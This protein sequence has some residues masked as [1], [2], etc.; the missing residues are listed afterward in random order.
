MTDNPSEQKIVVGL[1]ELLWDLLPEG[2]R[3]GGA[4]ANFAVMAGRLGDHAVIASRLGADSLGEQARNVLDALPVDCSFLQTDAEFATG[5]VTVSFSKGEPH[6]AIHQ[7]AAWDYLTLTPEWRSLAQRADAVCFGTLAQ[8]DAIARHTIL[9]FLDATRPSCVRVFDVNLR[10]PFWTADALRY[11]LGRSTILKLNARELPLV[12]EKTGIC[13]HPPP[14][15]D[16]EV[17]RGAQRLLDR[18]PLAMVCV[19]LG[20]EGS[21]LVTREHSHRRHGLAATVRDTIGAGD[22]FTAALTHYHLEGALLPVLNEA[23]NR[24][25]AWMAS[26]T[27]AMPPLPAETLASMAVEIRRDA[28]TLGQVGL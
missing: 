21:L 27:G 22:A 13:P 18:Y 8:R 12:L 23:G 6:Y 9:E 25:G 28:P 11:S 26:Q 7:P 19:T 3:L 4:P 15:P 16:D 20:A 1:G 24:W 17:L 5:T 14:G 2:P 10:A